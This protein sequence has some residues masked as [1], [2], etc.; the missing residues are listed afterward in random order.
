[1]KLPYKYFTVFQKLVV[2]V[3]WISTQLVIN[4]QMTVCKKNKA[5]ISFFRQTIYRQTDLQSTLQSHKNNSV[6]EN[7]EFF[8]FMHFC[9][10]CHSGESRI[11][12]GRRN[13]FPLGKFTPAGLTRC[14]QQCSHV[15][16]KRPQVSKIYLY[17]LSSWMSS[18]GF[19]GIWSKMGSY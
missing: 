17:L 13:P 3:K 15:S 7:Y 6:L 1:M 5:F 8:L 16:R 19:R 2:C 11:D 10:A 9:S 18:F 12:W 4:L 14:G